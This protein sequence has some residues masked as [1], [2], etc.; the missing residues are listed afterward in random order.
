L[1]FIGLVAILFWMSYEMLVSPALKQQ[2]DVIKSSGDSV[3]SETSKMSL[4]PGG[5]AGAITHALP[6]LKFQSQDDSSQ[7]DVEKVEGKYDEPDESPT[8]ENNPPDQLK[9]KLQSGVKRVGII[10]SA[11]GAFSAAG[12]KKKRRGHYDRQR[13][14]KPKLQIAGGFA[15]VPL[16]ELTLSDEPTSIIEFARY[17]TIRDVAYSDD[18]KWLAI[19][20]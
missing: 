18:G 19:T 9:V 12:R 20:W 8:L 6:F 15:T 16:T 1:T 11:L 10:N 2:A 4:T 13:R 14:S 5:I 3:H 17:G 7:D